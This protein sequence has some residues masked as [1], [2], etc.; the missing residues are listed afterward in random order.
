[1]ESVINIGLV[2]AREAE[3]SAKS[4]KRVAQKIFEFRKK[5]DKIIQKNS[6]I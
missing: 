1:M 2:D 6:K 5:P 3:I 4:K